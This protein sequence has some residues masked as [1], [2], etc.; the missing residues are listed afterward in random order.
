MWLFVLQRV[1]I[2]FVLDFFYFPIWWY[3]L[4]TKKAIIY[5]YHFFQFGNSNLAP[6]VWFQNMFVP[7]F[8]Q[9]DFQGRIVSFLVRIA[10][11]FFRTIMLF[12]WFIFVL[13]L[14]LIWLALPI[15]LAFIIINLISS[16]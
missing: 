13:I 2:E 4:G 6:F 12:V 7:M 5:C 3:S 11:I 10:N 8:G 14:F 15:F 9:Y 1:F 16:K